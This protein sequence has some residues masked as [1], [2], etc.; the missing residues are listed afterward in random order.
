MPPY[1]ARLYAVSGCRP[2]N[3]AQ[4]SCAA[5]SP[6]LLAK[7]RNHRTWVTAAAAVAMVTGWRSSRRAWRRRTAQAAASGSGADRGSGVRGCGQQDV[8]GRRCRRPRSSPVLLSASRPG[9]G[10]AVVTTALPVL[11][12]PR[13]P[14]RTRPGALQLSGDANTY[15]RHIPLTSGRGERRRSPRPAPAPVPAPYRC[16]LSRSGSACRRMPGSVE[17]ALERHRSRDLS[18]AR[19]DGDHADLGAGLRG[20]RDA[21]AVVG[22]LRA[23][24]PAR[25]SRPP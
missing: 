7:K 9:F 25:A 12:R 2:T 20:V 18:G 15:L 17:V 1:Q 21:L 8:A 6:P 13:T 4:A 5:M 16:V 22:D 23:R 19:A 3:S 14:F 11:R 24:P 10:S